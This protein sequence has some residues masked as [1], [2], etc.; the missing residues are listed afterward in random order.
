MFGLK[1]WFQGWGVLIWLIIFSIE[2]IFDLQKYFV[3]S[4]N[5][6]HILIDATAAELQQHL[7]YMNMIFDSWSVF[8]QWQKIGKIME[9]KEISLVTPNP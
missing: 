2:K 1:M 8:W 6:F 7:L 3:G 5:H 4:W 9:F